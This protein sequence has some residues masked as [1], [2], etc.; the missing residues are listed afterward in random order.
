MWKGCETLL[1]AD[2]SQLHSLSPGEP[3]VSPHPGHWA[4]A[5]GVPWQE[6][7][8]AGRPSLYPS[9]ISNTS[10]EMSAFSDFP[11]PEDFPVFLPNAQLLD[12]LQRYAEHFSLREH[13]KLGVSD[14]CPA[15][16]CSS[17][18]LG[19]SGD[20]ASLPCFRPPLSASV[21]TLT[22]PPRASG[23]WS[24][25]RVGSRHRM[26]LMLLWF[27]AAISPSHPSP[28]TV[29]LVQY[30]AACSYLLP[31]AGERSFRG[32][33]G[34]ILPSFSCFCFPNLLA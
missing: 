4:D 23:M 26:S 34:K 3:G 18:V 5:P 29:F 20:F 8:E 31:G 11:F 6:H 1:G 32:S 2:L 24:Q 15:L 28:C 9:V 14:W 7:I 17:P 22:L 16:P 19:A 13:I 27:A 12:Y 21:N 30:K 33:L 10:K 25:R